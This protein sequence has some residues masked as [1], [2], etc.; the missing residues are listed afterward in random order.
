MSSIS[1]SIELFDPGHCLVE[2]STQHLVRHA[3]DLLLGLSAFT[4]TALLPIVSVGY[5]KK[6]KETRLAKAWTTIDRLLVIWK[7]DVTD[8]MKQFSSKQW[9]CRYRY[10]VAPH[11]WTFVEKA[12]WHLHKNAVSHIEQDLE[13]TPYK[14]VAVRPPTTHPENSPN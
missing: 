13:A 1:S 4:S 6:K 7:S 9:L 2:F 12:S 3:V 8:K 14:T 10:M 5:L 11:G